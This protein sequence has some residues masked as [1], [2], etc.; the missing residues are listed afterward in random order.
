MLLRGTRLATAMRHPW[1][2]ATEQDTFVVFFTFYQSSIRIARDLRGRRTS[3]RRRGL[4]RER[5]NCLDERES[6]IASRVVVSSTTASL[7]CWTNPSLFPLSLF[8]SLINTSNSEPPPPGNPRAFVSRYDIFISVPRRVY[9]TFL[10]VQVLF[11]LQR[12][13]ANVFSYFVP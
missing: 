11:A 9:L 6:I 5:W 10:L 3:S 7:S 1:H 8:V 2:G 4:E 13:K 12:L